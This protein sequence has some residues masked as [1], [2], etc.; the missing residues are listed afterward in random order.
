MLEEIASSSTAHQP[1]SQNRKHAKQQ[2]LLDMATNALGS[3]PC[4]EGW[5]SAGNETVS[6]CLLGNFLVLLGLAMKTAGERASERRRN[7]TASKHTIS[8]A[9]IHYMY[10]SPNTTNQAQMT[11][12]KEGHRHLAASDDELPEFRPTGRNDRR[13]KSPVNYES[14]RNQRHTF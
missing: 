14:G 13:K 12:T 4:H 10:T 1:H 3:Q 7:G 6:E 11:R 5:P 9:H 8:Y 2:G